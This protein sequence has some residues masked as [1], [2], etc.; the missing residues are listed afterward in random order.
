[1]A[2]AVVMVAAGGC[3]LVREMTD[4]DL[5]A[6]RPFGASTTPANYD[7]LVFNDKA[8]DDEALAKAFPYLR[9][10]R[11]KGLDF[12]GRQISDASVPL[13]VQIQS[14]RLLRVQ[15]TRISLEGLKRLATGLPNL[16]DLVVDG[17][18]FGEAEIGELRAAAP[19]VTIF[20]ERLLIYGPDWD[21]ENRDTN[22][23]E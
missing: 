21:A 15:G 8:M 16:N 7:D 2:L 14:L 17:K 18:R 10:Y 5:K 1:M 9:R 22:G 11:P 19:K 3:T 4:S 6:L 13:L 20:P 12:N 23:V